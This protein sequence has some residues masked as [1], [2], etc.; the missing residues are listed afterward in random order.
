M[1]K[2]IALLLMACAC[3][4]GGQV[5]EL[6]RSSYVLQSNDVGTAAYSDADDFV[7]PITNTYTVVNHAATNA[8]RSLD[9]IG[10]ARYGSA[11]YIGGIA[12]TT[13]YAPGGQNITTMI[14]HKFNAANDRA[15][16]WVPAGTKTTITDIYFDQSSA[17]NIGGAKILIVL[18]DTD[19]ADG[20]ASSQ[21]F[22]TNCAS[23]VE[24]LRMTNTWSFSH[25][26]FANKQIQVFADTLDSPLTQQRNFY[27]MGVTWFEATNE[28]ATVLGTLIKDMQDDW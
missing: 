20:T 14:V 1:K 10:Q 24:W 21:A 15:A 5:D 8:L 6:T 25:N 7:A 17:T 13:E 23:T 11:S 2:L 3:A 12:T 18:R 19:P 26:D 9:V 16:W 4:Y 27:V 28:T 22:E